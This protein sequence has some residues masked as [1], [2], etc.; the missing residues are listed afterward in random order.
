[1]SNN[2]QLHE[3]DPVVASDGHS[4]EREAIMQ[5]IGSTRISPITRDNL[6]PQVYPNHTLKKNSL[7]V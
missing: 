6:L 2:T 5:V 3:R 7:D 4:Y 1:M